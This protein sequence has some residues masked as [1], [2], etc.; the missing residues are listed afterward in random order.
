[1][2]CLGLHRKIAKKLV[3]QPHL[4]GAELRFLRLEMDQ[5]Q[6]E[7]A[8]ALGTSEQTLSLWERDRNKPMPETA[9]KLLRV[10]ADVHLKL[11]L[12]GFIERIIK[13]IKFKREER[14]L[15]LIAAGA[16]YRLRLHAATEHG[17]TLSAK[18]EPAKS[19]PV[20]FEPVK[21]RKQAKSRKEGK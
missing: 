18:S 20:K 4:T 5:T 3:R 10:V 14:R 11:G 16:H 8:K 15:R 2:T 13:A 6:A 1:M 7:L 21:S 9:N 12:R 17:T 19:K